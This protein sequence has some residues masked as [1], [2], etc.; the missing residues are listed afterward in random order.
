M[1]TGGVVADFD[2][3]TR[4]VTITAAGQGAVPWA[5]TAAV[6]G[7]AA[8]GTARLGADLPEPGATDPLAAPAVAVLIA[9]PPLDVR[10][11]V[12][13]PG[14]VEEVVL[15]PAPDPG[16]IADALADAAPAALVHLLLETLRSTLAGSVP[17][18]A[19]ALDE[20]LA[21]L[22]LLGT[23][24]D[25]DSPRPLRLPASLLRDPAAWLASLPSGLI[26]AG[27]SLL[28]A[29]R[30]LLGAT[31]PP[32]TLDVSDGVTLRAAPAGG[33]L[34]LAVELD[35]TA[36][37]APAGGLV[38]VVG[39]SAGVTVGIGSPALPDVQLTLTVPGAGAIRLGVGAGAGGTLAVTLALAPDG[40]AEI[41]L[42]PTGPG[43]G[44]AAAAAGAVAVR[45]L[46]PLLD[47][48]A[49]R[50]PA[51]TADEPLE[52][53]GRL[54]ARL[55]DALGLRVG[56]PTSRRFDGDALAAFGVDPA[57]ALAAHAATLAATGLTLLEQ[58][59]GP[60][61][62]GAAS[63][64]VTVTT[65]ALVVTVGDLE[66]RWLPGTTRVEVTVTATGVPGVE[67]VVASATLDA[68]GL[69]V[70]DVAAGPAEL[71]AGAVVVRP[72]ARTRAGTAVPGGPSVEVGLGAGGD[73]LLVARWTI[74]TGAF[75]L[76]ASD[77][78]IESPAAADVAAAVLAVVV[79]LAGSVVLAI[80]QVRQ[81]LTRP[82]LGTTAKALLT[83]VLLEDAAQP[84]MLPDVLDPDTV[85]ER[86]ATLLGNLAAAPGASVTID[87][88]LTLEPHKATAGPVDT[89]GLSLSL[90]KPFALVTEGI[91]VTLE[92]DASWITPPTGTAPEGLTV[93]AL[94]VAAD[95]AVT[96]RPGLIVGGLGV[97]FGQS[98]GPL[99]DAGIT[100]DSLGLLVFADI[101]ATNGGAALAGGARLE[102]AGLAVPMAGASGG[103]NAVAQG[104]LTSGG[105]EEPPEPAFSPAVAV[106]RHPGG[107]TLVTLSAG[108]GTGP[109]WLVIQRTFGPVY[110]EQVGFAVTMEQEQ[111]GSFGLLIDG[112]VSLLGL[113]AAVDDLSLTYLVSSGKSALDPTAWRAD[114]AGFAVT[115]DVA[116]ITLAGGLRRFPVDLGGVEYLG[117]LLARFGVY[118][119]T[120]YGGYGLVGPADDQ[121]DA[122]FLF[123]AVNG[124][125]GGPPAFFVTG[126]GGGFGINRAL[127]YPDDL[128]DFG[129]YPFIKA[130]D[131]AARP[132]DPM[133]ELE[134]VRDFFPAERGTFW[135]A[136]GLSFTSFALVDG[137]AVVAVQIGEGFELTLL[138]LA[139][140][141]LPRPQAAIVSVELGL[142]ARFSS[143]EGLLLVQ[144][145]LTDNSWLLYPSVRLTG[146]FAFATWFTGSNRGQFVLT[147]GGY[148]PS[149]R[150]E[151]YPQ[152]PRLGISWQV[153][154]AIGITGESYFALTSEA[155]MAGARVEAHADF[156][157]A[158]ASLEVGGDG[159]VFFDPFWLSV[160]VYA[161]ISAGV[162]VDVWIGEITISVSLSARVT[163]E[164]PPFHGKA[165]FSVGPVDL[166]VEFGDRPTEPL[167][168]PWDEFAA[169]YLEEAAPGEAHV[170][171]G[172][173]GKG[174]VPPAGSSSTGGAPSPDGSD[175][176]PFRVMPEF[177]FTV[178]STAPVRELVIA[179]ATTNLPTVPEVSAAP[180]RAPAKPKVTLRLT[181][182]D[183]ATA[184]EIGRLQFEPQQLGAFAIGTW[185]QAQSQD[186]PK[187]PS[188]EVL[189]AVDRVLLTGEAT[190]AEPTTGSAP[191]IKYRQVEIG[192]Q[193]RPLPFVVEYTDERR[194]RLEIGAGVLA[195]LIPA[196]GESGTLAVA[197][198]LLATRA[199]RGAADVATWIGARSAAPL[200]GSLA[201]GLGGP[202]RLTK[203][204]PTVPPEPARPAALRPPNIAA[205]LSAPAGPAPLARDDGG[206]GAV[207]TVGR[208]LRAALAGKLPVVVAPP[209]RLDAVDRGLDAATPARLLRLAD[210]AV[211]IQQTVVAAGA[212]P[213]TRT[214]R[215]G[216]EAVGGRGA[217]P[218]ATARL[219]RLRRALLGGGAELTDGDVALLRLPDHTRDVDPRRRPG[220]TV[221]A[222]RLRVVVLLPGSRVAA[223]RMLDKGAQLTVAPGARSVVC[224]AGVPAAGRSGS[225]PVSGW[226]AHTPVAYT[227]DEAWVGAGVTA[228]SAGRVPR[229]GLANAGAGWI[230]PE[231][232]VAGR[233]AVVTRFADQVT[234]VAVA[235]EG[236]HATDDDVALGLAGARR[237]AGP[238]GRPLAPVVVADGPRTV[239]I[240]A[241]VP[242]REGDREAD[243]ITVTV[244]TAPERRLAGVA[245]T[246]GTDPDG[247]GAAV[248]ARGLPDLVPPAAADGLG[249]HRIIWKEP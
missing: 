161:S 118:G 214:G 199:D 207:T 152:V 232:L 208:E 22:G 246:S 34:A 72:Y 244:S 105:E 69:L 11:R 83:D 89:Y 216:A 24:P 108:P 180:M 177:E 157:P 234:V 59:L 35:G 168:I 98:G 179:G 57:S 182:P 4:A 7:G 176:A 40:G 112:S 38:L 163:L 245:G 104:L 238:D 222:G 126:I 21:A 237:A 175:A 149:F 23:A 220:L 119:I 91:T 29:L 84:R 174:A 81:A 193:R 188:G 48:L 39:G 143:T 75:A 88:A 148:H 96:F 170:L 243:A 165:S 233:T 101:Q 136:A 2:L 125:I 94:S 211:D 202:I 230:A 185:G 62:G 197:A 229:R 6:A 120:V 52:I 65:G 164:G 249:R 25:E 76:L 115:S 78:A 151:G 63:R 206:P 82:L 30:A 190:I 56:P 135:F 247:F 156:G 28:D 53:A 221:T 64:G 196:V 12:R 241:I 181:G 33:R 146:G 139:R 107:P 219:A 93:T 224:L 162:T 203:V 46:P 103:D 141:A 209:A 9:A 195:G 13:H 114:L 171:A 142:I 248:A 67:T 54:V 226:V 55:G 172:V 14:R 231:A 228:R 99:L 153:S 223:D 27:P 212:P 31:G 210:P 73:D 1:E 227:G 110:I 50:D 5:A 61:L 144:A 85:P 173:P 133:A 150:R 111:I 138:G 184:D 128:S 166:T 80:A 116:G 32:G 19:A 86:L 42:L 3:A 66:L 192:A 240:F 201:E 187:V 36:F 79:E 37:P 225:P 10:L 130:L 158:W 235:V 8:A 127:T 132:G 154:S 87:D 169:K 204:E 160:T 147:L 117:L 189:T 159:I 242:A 45:A 155:V 71:A 60:V 178:T 134:S 131:P 200:L 15:W 47:A 92:D 26:A 129:T 205:L 124:P 113:S 100:L 121:F 183:G 49:A 74:A 43:L 145:Q 77:G 186:D 198:D 18:A 97:R 215:A 58:A 191:A 95:G 167:E 218:E 109:W 106:Q 217:D 16:A 140:M 17:A 123:G 44:G 194:E 122:L 236:G 51:G 239:S 68:T 213:A 102:L 137:V 20:L 90:T 41:P 70:L